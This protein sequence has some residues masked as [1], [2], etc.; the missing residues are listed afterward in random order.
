MWDSS[1]DLTTEIVFGRRSIY[2]VLQNTTPALP[3]ILIW[4]KAPT[5]KQ[6]FE[7]FSFV[8]FC[9]ESIYFIQN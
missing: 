1:P 4:L 6:Y 8:D 2:T 3:L 9:N 5:R 7:F